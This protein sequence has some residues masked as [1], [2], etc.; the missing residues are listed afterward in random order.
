MYTHHTRRCLFNWPAAM[1]FNSL[2]F[3]LGTDHFT[4]PESY[5]F[6]LGKMER[7]ILMPSNAA[8]NWEHDIFIN[9][10]ACYQAFIKYYLL[11]NTTGII[12][13]WINKV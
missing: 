4:Q 9:I 13:S 5:I 6:R 3:I 1:D 2:Y 7:K 12:L 8:I 11:S 10:K